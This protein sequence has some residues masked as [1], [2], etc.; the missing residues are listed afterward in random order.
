[1]KT[2]TLLLAASLEEEF[3]KIAIFE[4]PINAGD[5]AGNRQLRS[6]LRTAIAHHYGRVAAKDAIGYCDGFVVAGGVAAVTAAA[7][8][9]A[10]A[11]MPCFLQMVGTGLTTALMLHLGA[12]SPAARWPAITCHELYQHSLLRER[13]PVSGGHMAVPEAP[14]LGVELD[15]NAVDTYRVEQAALELPRRLIRYL[16]PSGLAVYFTADS[17]P[18]SSMWRF[19]AAGNQPAFE[20]GVS[21]ELIDDDGGAEFADLYARAAE[22]PVVTASG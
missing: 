16:R 17:K 9:A 10:A 22:A 2:I 13:L 14:G 20:G 8:T 3:A 6:Q 12:V 5:V 19:F 11:N 1:M 21:T 15:R 7:A 4:G 18:G